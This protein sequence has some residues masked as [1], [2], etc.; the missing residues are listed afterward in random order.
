MKNHILVAKGSVT[1]KNFDLFLTNL[2]D[3]NLVTEDLWNV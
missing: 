3:R 2:T 1:S